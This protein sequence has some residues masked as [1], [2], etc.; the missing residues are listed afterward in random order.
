MYLILAVGGFYIYIQYGFARFIPGPYVDGYHKKIGTF[1]MALC[2]ASFLMASWTNP[3]VIKKSNMQRALKRFEYDGIMFKKGDECRTCK[4]M[5]PARSKHCSLCNVCVEKFDHHCIWINRCVGYYNYRYFLLFLITHAII[6]TY[7]SVVG[8][9]VFAGLIKEQNLFQAKFRNIKTGEEI[10]PTLWVVLRYLFDQESPFAFVTI[11]CICMSVMLTLFFIYHLWMALKN[12]T[13]NER[14]KRSDLIYY[15][16]R[17]ANLLQE[18]KDQFP[19]KDFL[20][21]RD[22]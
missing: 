21:T 17:K 5:K 1:I 9:L 22:K 6:C 15:F 11:L 7:G 13:T 14:A 12:T 19:S 8:I 20:S 16:E 2:Y 18:W 4:M 3:G 10:P